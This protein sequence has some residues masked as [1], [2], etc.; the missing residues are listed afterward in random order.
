[1]GIDMRTCAGAAFLFALTIGLCGPSPVTIEVDGKPIT[2]M[3]AQPQIIGGHTFVR[4]C[5]VSDALGVK[6]MNYKFESV[7]IDRGE[8]HWVFPVTGGVI[9]INGIEEP[10][11]LAP[12]KIGDNLYFPLRFVAERLGFE[13]DWDAKRRTVVITSAPPYAS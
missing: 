3:P 8:E 7:W 12:R 11:P 5:T 10:A 4:V 13:V 6:T 2:E 1:M 9:S